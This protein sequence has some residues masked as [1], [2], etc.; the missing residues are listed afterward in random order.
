MEYRS[1]GR[2]GVKVSPLC[3]GT[4]MFG[5]RAD[6]TASH[7]MIDH[8][9]EAGINFVD[10]ADAYGGGESERI[11]GEALSKDGRRAATVLATK[12]FFPQSGDPNDRGI[13]RRHVVDACDA[14][15]QRLRTDWIDLYQLHRSM[16]DIPIDETLRALDDLIRS[17]KVRYIGVSMFPGWQM[18]ESL[19]VAKELGLN[20]F[21]CEQPAY[22][23]LDR[24]IEREVVPAA[25]SFGV[26]VIPWGPLC[27]GVLTGK[28]RRGDEDVEGR[29]KGGAAGNRSI[30][31]AAF[32]VVEGLVELARERGCTPSQL[33]LAWC[34][35]QPGITA[36]IIGPRALEQLE[37]NLGAIGMELSDAERARL[38]ELAPPCSVTLPYWDTA[39]GLDLR[40]HSYR[41]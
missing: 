26:A 31:P 24:T 23:L 9:L 12:V 20:R 27:G 3:L 22:H 39:M 38:D 4:M 18:V 10:T 34:A 40:P 1:L 30:T 13:S 25:Q 29:W 33:A 37:D 36:P 32:D 11:V 2:T 21:V 8:A 19:W 7:A 15:L 35:S 17:G 14:S 5:S 16:A 28:Y 6:A 41:W